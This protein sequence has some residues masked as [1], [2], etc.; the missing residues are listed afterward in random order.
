M[1]TTIE[2]T[3]YS[4]KEL[5]E[6]EKTDK[7]YNKAVQRAREWL[8]DGATDYDWHEYMIELWKQALNQIGFE[9]AE[10][11]FSGFSSQGDGASFTASINVEKMIRFLA[12]KIRPTKVIKGTK[13]GQEDFTGFVVYH[14]GKAYNVRRKEYSPE[15]RKLLKRFGKDKLYL[16]DELSG[17]V[18]RSSH[19]YYHENTCD[20]EWDCRV[21]SPDEELQK[22]FEES[23]EELRTDLCHAIYRGLEEEYEYIMSDE[24]LL[25]NA[26]ANEYQFDICGR[27]E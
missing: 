21:D 24:S 26:E 5:M 8:Q 13:D 7:K 14:I 27:I 1:P 15:Y 6:L 4:F 18:Y 16:P 2:K 20:I 3:V 22:K 23:V 25:E 11:Q 9:D 12:K 17:K 10:I 19:H